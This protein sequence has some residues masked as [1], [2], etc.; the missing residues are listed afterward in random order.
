MEKHN[1]V[2]SLFAAAALG[3]CGAPN[4]QP[5]EDP[6]LGWVDGAQFPVAYRGAGVHVGAPPGGGL[7]SAVAAKARGKALSY[8]RFA[9]PGGDLAIDDLLPPVTSSDA[10]LAYVFDP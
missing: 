10:A 6:L 8:Y 4:L 5:V 9:F 1:Y 2:V 3:G 7:I